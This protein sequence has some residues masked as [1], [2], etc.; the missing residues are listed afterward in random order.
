MGIFPKYRI[1][2]ASTVRRE[3]FASVMFTYGCNSIGVKNPSFQ[4]IHPAEELNSAKRK[5]SL[6]QVRQF[7]IQAPEASLF[8]QVMDCQNSGERQVVGVHQH[9][10]ERRRPIVNVQY[11][12]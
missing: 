10:H 3:N 1:Q 5:E 2:A 9:R 4:Q 8:S 7:E 12:D 6:V 11:L